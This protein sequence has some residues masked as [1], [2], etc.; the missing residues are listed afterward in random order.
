[1]ISLDSAPNDAKYRCHW[2]APLAIDPF[3]HNTVYYGCQMILKTNNEGHSWT[4]FSP[5]LST[6][7]PSRILSNGGL[8]GD[9]LGQYDGEV[10]WS[11]EYS[12]IKQGLIWAGTNDGKL[13]YTDNDGRNWNDVTKNFTDLPPW[14][15][16][17]QIWPSTFDPAEAYVAVSLHLMDD[18]K[19]YIYKTTDFGKT[20]KKI[21]GN[22]PTGHP[23][24]YILSMSGNPNK[25]GM[26]FAGSARAFYYSMDDGG[27]WARFKDGLPPAPVSWITVEPRFH[28]VVLSTY[29]RGLFILP[30]ITMFEQTGQ[31]N[32][33]PPSQ[34]KLY[35]P[36]P[37]FR[38]ARSVYTQPNR[39]HFQI[40]LPAAPAEP[41]KMEILDE[42]GK[43]VRTE[44]V[45]LHQGL[46]G[47]NWDLA[48]DAPKLVELLT[49]PPDNPHI[50]EEERFKDV[51][52]RRI[53][54]W[55]I[56]PQTGVPMAAPGKF[57]VRFTVN[58]TPLTAPFEVMKDPAVAT[59]VD[60]LTLST[61]TQMRI[62]DDISETSTMV[63]KMEVWRRALEDH[64]KAN[65]AKPAVLK[66]IKDLDAKIWATENRLVSRS[67]IH[68]D[69]KYFPEAY[70]VYMN[71]IWLSGGVGQGASDEAGSID[72]K[73]TDTQMQVLEVI[74]K[75]LA[76]ARSEFERLQSTDIPAFN[77]AMAGKLPPMGQ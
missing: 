23:L 63:N 15:A 37:I 64:A 69:D 57:Q 13:W 12:K 42:G 75:E 72:Y 68:S 17:N 27:T 1:M 20:W 2:T 34:A 54:H 47:V 55:G 77:K 36:A 50:W 40:Y 22:I 9:N 11:I 53:T 14:G 76:T 66:A 16:F 8:V 51:Q 58:G 6:K 62:R 10:V 74:E 56:T 7:D 26:L 39:P 32:P 70:K 24:D 31:P 67:E 3:D 4:E 46:N 19:P 71:L 48:L 52:V 28:D 18:R 65:A 35:N 29:G 21:N 5:D 41:V 49:T 43:V 33:A 61:K 60:D 73:P 25:K 45:S 38:L 59:S 30:N 44:T